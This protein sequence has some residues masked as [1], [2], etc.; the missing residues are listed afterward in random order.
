MKFEFW[1]PQ[2]EAPKKGA[3]SP[4]QGAE[5]SGRG[6]EMLKKAGTLATLLASFNIAMSAPDADLGGEKNDPEN[7]KNK[8]ENSELLNKALI[9]IEQGGRPIRL[10]NAEAKSLEMEFQTHDLN[11]ISVAD[12][13]VVIHR[14]SKEKNPQTGAMEDTG[15]TTFV[16]VDR[17]GQPDR[18]INNNDSRATE[19]KA[20]LLGLQKD[21]EDFDMVSMLSQKK[22]ETLMVL[23]FN[24][25]GEATIYDY[26]S[27]NKVELD[28]EKTAGFINSAMN[29][30]NSALQELSQ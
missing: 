27:G 18:V 11:A 24:K 13:P 15:I 30:Y 16:D 19:A 1:K 2:S 17:D 26:T 25:D 20:Q 28:K 14:H 8:T 5:K 22:K 12:G 10:T 3:T 21:F 29:G 9:K 23:D 7:L 4:D 6:K